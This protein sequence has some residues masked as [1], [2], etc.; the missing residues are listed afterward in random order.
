MQLSLPPALRVST[1]AQ[2][3]LGTPTPVRNRSGLHPP[4][5][6]AP[7]KLHRAMSGRGLNINR[8]STRFRSIGRA[9]G[10]SLRARQANPRAAC[11]PP[12]V[13]KCTLEALFPC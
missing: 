6:T 2:P 11:A 3:P 10:V 4:E 1:P 7:A 8:P 9:C 5:I 12:D 13:E